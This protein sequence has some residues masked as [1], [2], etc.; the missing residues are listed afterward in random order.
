MAKDGFSDVRGQEMAERAVT[1]AAAG[2][3]NLLIICTGG[4]SEWPS[5]T[6]FAMAQRRC[7][8]KIRAKQRDYQDVMILGVYGI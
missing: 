1:I 7:P 8:A 5:M 2:A 6:V 4:K 3:H